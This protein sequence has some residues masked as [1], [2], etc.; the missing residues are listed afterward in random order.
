MVHQWSMNQVIDAG[1][2]GDSQDV[3]RIEV[4]DTTTKEPKQAVFYILS[5]T[6][7]VIGGPPES[8]PAGAGL[9]APLELPI[10]GDWSSFINIRHSGNAVRSP[11][12]SL[13][14]FVRW[15]NAEEYEHGISKAWLRRLM[16]DPNAPPKL[17][18]AQRYIMANVVPN[19]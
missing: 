12:P 11:L 8:T 1:P 13:F 5:F 7:E 2:L 15:Q 3:W 9:P 17:Q 4:Q 10:R 16:D 6:G 14:S 18:V 19:R